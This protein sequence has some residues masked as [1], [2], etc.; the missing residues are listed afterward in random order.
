VPYMPLETGTK[1]PFET[2]RLA[3]VTDAGEAIPVP[4]VLSTFL[5][6][7]VAAEPVGLTCDRERDK[8]S[9]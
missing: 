5:R 9:G 7:A 2:T 6:V 3:T 8:I 4:G 1:V